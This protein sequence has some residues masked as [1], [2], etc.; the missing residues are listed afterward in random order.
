[1]SQD[2]QGRKTRGTAIGFDCTSEPDNRW[3]ISTVTRLP[4]STSTGWTP[5][6][7]IT[8]RTAYLR[9]RTVCPPRIYSLNGCALEHLAARKAT[10]LSD[11]AY[12]CKSTHNAYLTEGEDTS[13]TRRS[14]RARQEETFVGSVA[15]DLIPAK[16][17]V[18]TALSMGS[19]ARLHRCR[20]GQIKNSIRFADPFGACSINVYRDGGEHGWHFDESEFTVTLSAA[21]PGAREDAFEY[22][23][24]I[25]ET[26]QTKNA[27]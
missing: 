4:I 1:M 24:M 7:Q 8:C 9:N 10:T 25:L 21:G 13:T 16:R 19:I 26:S 14:V 23:P 11:K 12:F 2:E 3:S 17:S 5:R 20:S 15:Y 22:V 27:L 6:S 18:E